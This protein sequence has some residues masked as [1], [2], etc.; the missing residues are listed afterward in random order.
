MLWGNEEM[1]GEEKI[2][3]LVHLD[4]EPDAANIT[5]STLIRYSDFLNE[6]YQLKKQ[7]EAHE[8]EDDLLEQENKEIRLVL[9]K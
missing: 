7:S 4:L 8:G 2:F 3:K 6:K 5:D 1:K 9:P